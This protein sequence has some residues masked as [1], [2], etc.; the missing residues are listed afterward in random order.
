RRT[1]L[2]EAGCQVNTVLVHSGHWLGER[3]LRPASLGRVKAALDSI[4]AVLEFGERVH[5]NTSLANRVIATPVVGSLFA[6][7][8]LMAALVHHA[9]DK[10]WADDDYLVRFEIEALA[11]RFPARL[12][13]HEQGLR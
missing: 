6:T 9:K 11:K 5:G 8:D 2:G 7:L 4:H 10:G 13:F 12:F 1:D 3:T